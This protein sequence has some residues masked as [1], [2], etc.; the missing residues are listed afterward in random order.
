[1]RKNRK[2][3]EGDCRR[4]GFCHHLQEPV[5]V[6]VGFKTAWLRTER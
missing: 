1:M 5:E 3:M 2:L 6:V 4:R